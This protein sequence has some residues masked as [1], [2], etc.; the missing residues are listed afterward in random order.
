[1]AVDGQ[2]YKDTLHEPSTPTARSMSSLRSPADD[3]RVTQY[4]HITLDGPFA[5]EQDGP[6]ELLPKL[7]RGGRD[8]GVAKVRNR[9]RSRSVYIVLSLIVYARSR[10]G[11]GWN[12]G[13]ER[14]PNHRRWRDIPRRLAVYPH[15]PTRQRPATWRNI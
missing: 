7:L 1:M 4:G 9:H 5:S 11:P 8:G 6:S 14:V 2:V 15:L 10:P 3:D 12:P 13:H